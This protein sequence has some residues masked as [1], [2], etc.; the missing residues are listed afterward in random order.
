MVRPALR[1]NVQMEKLLLRPTE[2]ADALGVSR[3]TIYELVA[4]GT[5]PS[6]RLGRSVRVPAESLRE[7]VLKSSE[8]D[9]KNAV[10]REMGNSELTA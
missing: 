5:V 4:D 3:S 2:A 7:W 8:R 6:M 9:L 10:G 1:R